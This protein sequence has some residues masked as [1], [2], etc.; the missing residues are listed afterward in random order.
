MK[1]REAYLAL[2]LIPQVGPVRLRR[3]LDYFGGPQAVL[4]A[5][6]TQ[7]AQVKGIDQTLA[8]HIAAWQDHIDLT[9]ELAKIRDLGLT[10]LMPEDELYPPLLRQEP[11]APFLLYVW[12]QLQKRDHQ[13]IGVVGSRQATAYGMNAAKKFSF[14][15]AYAG[16]TVISGL[17]RGIDTA[18][19]ESALAAKGRTIAVIGSGIGK[20]YPP[21][22]QALAARI[23]ENGAV[24]S[25]YP[26]D[27]LA[28]KQTFPYRNRIV[29]GWSHGLLVVEAPGRSGSL[30]TAQ[31]ALEMGRTIYAVPGNFDRPTSTGCNRLIQQGAKLVLDGGDILDDLGA[32][33]PA[34]NRVS[35]PAPTAAATASLENLSLDERI[36]FD[37]IG[38]E[39]THVDEIITRSGLTPATVSS[40]LM[41]L[42]MKRLVRQLP[43]RHY[44][45]L[46]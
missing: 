8:E 6:P 11:T 2:N 45:K 12:G 20:L 26:V 39:E 36:L 42:E 16:Y 37:A 1:E 32:L 31:Q 23:A 40:S 24:I 25:E 41:R 29:A 5:K 17:A 46:V 15:I 14:Q 21:E 34:E 30:I 13:A 27:R 33:F 18:A 4:A 35:E 9:G 10:L 19:H 22:N 7:L 3:M 44:I 43:G 38:T 28:D